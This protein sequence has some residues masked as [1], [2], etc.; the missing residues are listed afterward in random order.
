MNLKNCIIALLLTVFLT[1][2]CSSN[3]IKQQTELEQAKQLIK[4]QNTTKLD[5]NTIPITVHS[6]LPEKVVIGK[7]IDI[8]VEIIS[9]IDLSELQVIYEVSP[10]LKFRK[11]WVFIKQDSV[12]ATIKSIKSDKLYKQMI[13][14]VPK[15]EGLLFV[16]VYTIYSKDNVKIAKKTPITLS[17]GNPLDKS[18]RIPT[19]EQY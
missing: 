1:I 19:P 15:I 13:R 12:S 11:K 16:N 10:G 3:K 9:D 6:V 18:N 17:I 7:Q 14:V 5:A 8:G 4:D 2:G